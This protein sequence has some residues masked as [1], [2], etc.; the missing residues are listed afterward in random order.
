MKQFEDETL[1]PVV[2]DI[3]EDRPTEYHFDDDEMLWFR[4]SDCGVG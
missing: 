4:G 1:V 3:A 2:E